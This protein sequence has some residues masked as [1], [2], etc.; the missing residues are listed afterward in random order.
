MTIEIT[1]EPPIKRTVYGRLARRP[2]HEGAGGGA[3]LFRLLSAE[4]IKAATQ[5]APPARTGPDSFGLP[6]QGGF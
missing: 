1:G 5:P 4:A 3:V 6:G 2:L